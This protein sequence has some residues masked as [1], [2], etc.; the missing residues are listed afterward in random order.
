MLLGDRRALSPL[1]WQDG[2]SSDTL[3]R[4]VS[5][6]L[7]KFCAGSSHFPPCCPVRPLRLAH[8]FDTRTGA[9]WRSRLPRHDG[10]STQRPLR[11]SLRRRKREERTRRPG[12]LAP[13]RRPRDELVPPRVPPLRDPPLDLRGALRGALPSPT[14]PHEHTAHHPTHTTPRHPTHP[15]PQQVYLA[16]FGSMQLEFAAL[17]RATGNE[18]FD[19]LAE[20]ALRVVFE[21]PQRPSGKAAGLFQTQWALD[22]GTPAND[23]VGTGGASDSFYEYLLKARGAPAAAAGEQVSLHAGRRQNPAVGLGWR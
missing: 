1:E 6:Q 15:P 14:H 7:R 22:A 12:P 2:I 11:A 13:R 19:D 21:S 9:A 4:I 16:E 20:R 3:K 17:S 8:S 18:T 23:R 10:G 5:V